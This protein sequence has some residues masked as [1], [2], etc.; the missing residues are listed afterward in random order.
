MSR[1]FYTYL[2]IALVLAG[3]IFYMTSCQFLKN[4][5]EDVKILEQSIEQDIDQALSTKNEVQKTV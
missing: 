4:H 1:S 5:P 3:A 2:A